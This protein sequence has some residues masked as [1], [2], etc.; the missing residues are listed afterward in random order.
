MLKFLTNSWKML[1]F[2]Q[3]HFI[4]IALTLSHK[5][6]KRQQFVFMRKLIFSKNVTEVD[7][8]GD[9]NVAPKRGINHNFF[10]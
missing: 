7:E 1:K 5:Y 10:F 6:Q 8:G 3:I 9:V 4:F 2:Q